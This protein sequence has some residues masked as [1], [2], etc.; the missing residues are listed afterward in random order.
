MDETKITLGAEDY[1]DTTYKLPVNICLDL[2]DAAKTKDVLEAIQ[3][4]VRTLSEN[5]AADLSVV[6][7]VSAFNGVE[8]SGYEK[9][10]VADVGK[11]YEKSFGG[12]KATAG[13]VGALHSI[14]DVRVETGRQLGLPCFTP[15]FLMI[16]DGASAEMAGTPEVEKAKKE[17]YERSESKKETVVTVS[18]EIADGR[19]AEAL[20]GKAN[21]LIEGMSVYQPIQI[22]S[23]E[24]LK[25]FFARTGEE[26]I[27]FADG[28]T[29]EFSY[30]DL[31]A[32]DEF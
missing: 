18:Y 26:I 1:A 23:L 2:A 25:E 11:M 24:K 5:D 14:T 12:E 17:T 7:A 28:R 32:W 4:L 27:K 15:V 16:T 6:I 8:A 22:S 13:G 21:E 20:F 10:N 9:C 19:E 29:R 3:E 30:A 31:L